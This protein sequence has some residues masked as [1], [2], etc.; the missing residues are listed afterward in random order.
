M[1]QRKP[2]RR[3]VP[4]PPAAKPEPEAILDGN[5]FLHRSV[6]KI[7]PEKVEIRPALSA[8]IAPLIGVLIGGGAF[9]LVLLGALGGNL[10]IW[11][12]ALSLMFAVILLPLSGMGLVYSLVGASVVIDSRKNSIT[13]QQGLLG[14][15][16][17]T[18]ELVPFEKIGS[19]QVVEVARRDASSEEV[20]EE[21]VAQWDL[22]LVKTSGRELTIATVSS[23]QGMRD[24]GLERMNA[25]ARAVSRVTGKPIGARAE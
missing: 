8:A 7:R 9:T 17:G 15:G 23:I 14:M 13:W 20:A 6:A 11:L 19:L 5:V 10:P 21:A 3:R 25:V 12:M 18:R 16:V 1:T 22:V 2:T 24:E 4:R